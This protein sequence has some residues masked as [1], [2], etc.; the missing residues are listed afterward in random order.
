MKVWIKKRTKRTKRKNRRRWRRNKARKM[1][2]KMMSDLKK[3]KKWK[4]NMKMSR[5]KICIIEDIRKSATMESKGKGST[6]CNQRNI[7]GDDWRSSWRSVKRERKVMKFV[8][9]RKA[10]MTKEP[11]SYGIYLEKMSEKLRKPD[12]IEG[13]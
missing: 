7:M 5:K 4:P 6:M 9:R 11:K 10:S 13:N 3:I 12:F 2:R 1:R 8:Q